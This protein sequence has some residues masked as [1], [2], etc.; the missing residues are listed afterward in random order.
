MEVQVVSDLNECDKPDD[1]GEELNREEILNRSKQD[2]SLER[3]ELGDEREDERVDEI[4]GVDKV[5]FEDVE[6]ETERGDDGVDDDSQGESESSLVDEMDDEDVED[7]DDR[8]FEVEAV[9]DEDEMVVGLRNDRVVEWWWWIGFEMGF[10]MGFDG[11][12]WNDDQRY[13]YTQ[14]NVCL[15]VHSKP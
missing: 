5:E 2:K 13:H 9:V 6:P 8:V 4:E 15:E 12:N 7:E 1:E 14:S 10:E 11:L 3:E